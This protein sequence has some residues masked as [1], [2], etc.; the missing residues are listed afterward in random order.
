MGEALWLARR[1]H[2]IKLFAANGPITPAW[3]DFLQRIEYSLTINVIYLEMP[4]IGKVS[5]EEEYQQAVNYAF[6]NLRNNTDGPLILYYASL[7][8]QVPKGIVC[9]LRLQ[10]EPPEKVLREGIQHIDSS[11]IGIICNSRRLL[12]IVISYVTG[13]LSDFVDYIPGGIDPKDPVASSKLQPVRDIDICCVL[14]FIERK[15]PGVLCDILE[16]VLEMRPVTTVVLVGDGPC[17]DL[18][19]RR[20]NKYFV[21]GNIVF[22]GEI[23]HRQVPALLRR[24][25]TFLHTAVEDSCPNT[26]QEALR[27]GVPVV[28]SNIGGVSELVDDNQSGYVVPCDEGYL[29][30]ANRVYRLIEDDVLLETFSKAA[31]NNAKRFFWSKIGP[32]LEQSYMAMIR[33]L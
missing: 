4:Y 2:I 11:L 5:I 24:S 29:G 26:V 23:P 21:N 32:R 22:T 15:A 14:R 25:C 19:R 7:L 17:R 9:V 28:T 12:K 16:C 30:M 13:I 1:G 31:S 18:I 20:L 3:K 27:E 33:R 6:S 8:K 10:G